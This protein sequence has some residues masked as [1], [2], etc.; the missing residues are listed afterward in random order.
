MFVVDDLRAGLVAEGIWQGQGPGGHREV[1]KP[2]GDSDES[3]DLKND[4][5]RSLPALRPKRG[6]AS[7]CSPGSERG[8]NID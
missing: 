5:H 4:L 7:L 3:R 1:H 2:Q 6:R 8:V